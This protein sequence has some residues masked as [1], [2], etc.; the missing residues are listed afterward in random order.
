MGG[1]S[2]PRSM[3]HSPLSL[4]ERKHLLP[5]LLRGRTLPRLISVP[6]SFPARENKSRVRTESGRY[7]A[8]FFNKRIEV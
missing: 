3:K 6:P 2:R 7:G 1:N 8:L 4:D 5:S